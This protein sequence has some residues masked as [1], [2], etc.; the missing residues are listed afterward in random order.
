MERRGFTLIEIIISLSILSILIVMS[1][2][3]VYGNE[4]IY[5]STSKDIDGNINLRIGL[6]FLINEILDADKVELVDK[7]SGREIVSKSIIVTT[8]SGTTGSYLKIN[9]DLVYIKN[10]ILRNDTLS[11]Q[12]VSGIK[13]FSIEDRGEGLY[14]IVISSDKSSLST[15]IYKRK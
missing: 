11:Q 14:K 3:F 5:S 6:E 1:L 13:A 9:G 4:K 8:V 15:I 12:V 7:S 2:G 10:S